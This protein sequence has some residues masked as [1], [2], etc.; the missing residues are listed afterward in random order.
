MVCPCFS[1][2]YIYMWIFCLVAKIPISATPHSKWQK[3]RNFLMEYCNK[4]R[5][6][7]QLLCYHLDSVAHTHAHTSFVPSPSFSRCSFFPHK[8][9]SMELHFTCAMHI[10]I[11]QVRRVAENLFSSKFAFVCV[12]V[13]KFIYLWEGEIFHIKDSFV[14]KDFYQTRTFSC[15]LRCF[16]HNLLA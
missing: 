15:L 1:V 8:I 9:Y 3:H 12:C 10:P 6:Q 16:C 11:I 14:W 13:L 7:N 5:K 2:F 4:N